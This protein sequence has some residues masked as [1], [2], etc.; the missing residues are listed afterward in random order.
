MS[1]KDK[2]TR[3]KGQSSLFSFGVK[4]VANKESEEMNSI[5][6]DLENFEN[7]DYSGEGKE[8][9][10][11]VKKVEG[12]KEA[13]KRKPAVIFPMVTKVRILEYQRKYK[14]SDKQIRAEFN[15]SKQ[16]YDWAKS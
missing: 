2:I 6:Q 11:V 7:N 5:L 16:F 3:D 15:L 14:K 10:E 9:G 8:N 1:R 12:K 13:K 4:V